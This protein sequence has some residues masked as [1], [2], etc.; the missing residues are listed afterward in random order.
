[1]VIQW[2]GWKVYLHLH[3]LS[4]LWMC[5]LSLLCSR[6]CQVSLVLALCPFDLDKQHLLGS[7]EIKILSFILLFIIFLHDRGILSQYLC[8]QPIR[9]AIKMGSNTNYLL[10]HVIMLYLSQFGNFLLPC[11]DFF[12]PLDC[13]YTINSLGSIFHIHTKC[14]ALSNS[15]SKIYYK[16]FSLLNHD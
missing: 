4:D 8:T 2:Y 9:C 12:V 1:M 6:T 14:Q 10:V 16:M 5:Q 13:F 11:I 15:N 3:K 7:E